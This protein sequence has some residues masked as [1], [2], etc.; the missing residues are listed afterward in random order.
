MNHILRKYNKNTMPSPLHAY[1][2]QMTIKTINTT[3]KYL[4][5]KF[6]SFLIKKKN[7]YIFNTCLFIKVINIF[8]Y[9]DPDYFRI[10]DKLQVKKMHRT[11]SY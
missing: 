10:Y 8:S 1:L 2:P 6:L 4:H 5:I 9:V 7:E 3:S 11:N